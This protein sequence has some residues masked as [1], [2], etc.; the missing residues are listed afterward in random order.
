MF[1]LALLTSRLVVH[2]IHT[3]RVAWVITPNLPS[4]HVPFLMCCTDETRMPID[5]TDGHFYYSETNR[6]SQEG[7]VSAAMEWPCKQ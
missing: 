2:S 7:D 1:V 4:C 3:R 6:K 5:P